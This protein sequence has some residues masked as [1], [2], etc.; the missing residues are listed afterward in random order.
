MQKTLSAR[1]SAWITIL[2]KYIAG[3]LVPRVGFRK[4]II[5]GS[6]R[7]MGKKN[8]EPRTIKPQV[9]GCTLNKS[10]PSL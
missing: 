3:T 7:F 5:H 1:F 2:F 4:V 10:I 6:S 8:I 9:P